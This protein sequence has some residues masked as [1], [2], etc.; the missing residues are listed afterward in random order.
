[1]RNTLFLAGFKSALY[2]TLEELDLLPDGKYVH[3]RSYKVAIPIIF[4]ATFTLSFVY[5]VFIYPF[6][7][8]PLR[9]LPEPPNVRYTF[10]LTLGNLVRRLIY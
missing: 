6:Y 2:L 10:T 4:L 9:N 8:S 3:V 5:N 7:V 1:M